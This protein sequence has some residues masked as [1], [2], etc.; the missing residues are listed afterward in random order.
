[1]Q[2]L[3]TFTASLTITLSSSGDNTAGEEY[4]LT[5][6]AVING[7][8]DAP[9]ISWNRTRS[10]EMN[11]IIM[12]YDNGTHLNVLQFNPLQVS[13]QNTYSCEVRVVGITLEDVFSVTVKSKQF[14][15]TEKLKPNCIIYFNSSTS[16]C[17]CH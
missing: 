3:V 5:C 11:Q 2:L 6:T 14:A 15:S 7:S 17:Q 1:M 13:D 10:E 4:N 8:S 16:F 12:S 9:T